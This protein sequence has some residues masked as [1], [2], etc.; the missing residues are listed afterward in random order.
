M[1]MPSMTLPDRSL[2][3][4]A[5]SDAPVAKTRSIASNRVRRVFFTVLSLHWT[6]GSDAEICRSMISSS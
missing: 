3:R 4:S 2:T 6:I 1:N 5:E